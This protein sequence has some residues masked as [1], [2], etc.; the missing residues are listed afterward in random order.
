MPEKPASPGWLP[1]INRENTGR[2]I[3]K[4]N[5]I[6]RITLMNLLPKEGDFLSFQT[7]KKLRNELSPSDNERKKL[8][9]IQRENGGITWDVNADKGKEIEIND[10][11]NEVIVNS[12]KKLP[13]EDKTIP[14]A[15][16]EIYEKFIGSES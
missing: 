7:V 4:L 6:E 5:I 3:M 9:L 13:K 2:I 16:W 12:L 14:F 15:C 11:A 10:V 8:K 1:G